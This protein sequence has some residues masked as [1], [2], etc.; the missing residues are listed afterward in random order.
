MNSDFTIGKY[1]YEQLE[2]GL[3]LI[4]QPIEAAPV[5]SVQFAVSTGSIHENPAGHGLSHFLEHMIFKGSE[6]FPGKND[7]A[8]E[9]QRCGGYI[10]AYTT[11][12]HTCYHIDSMSE[13]WRQMTELLVDAMR[14]PLFPEEEFVIEKEVILREQ[15]M[16]EDNPNW[17]LQQA[18]WQIASGTHPF[19]IPVIGYRDKIVEVEREMM[20]NYYKRRYQ[21]RNSAV[22]VVGNVK[23]HEVI[24][25]LKELL[26]DWKNDI[27]EPLVIPQYSRKECHDRR[28]VF[29]EDNQAR[30]MITY[31]LPTGLEPDVPVLD[32]IETILSGSQ[33]AMLINR[34]KKKE[35]LAISV[36]AMSYT[37]PQSG[38]FSC[39]AS[40]VPEK[41]PQVEKKI[42]EIIED[43]REGRVDSKEIERAVLKSRISFLK[44]MQAVS[45]RAQL[46]VTAV[47][48]FDSPNYWEPYLKRL[49]EVDAE[50][51][52]DVA[53][54]YL[55]PDCAVVVNQW[56]EE[57]RE[58]VE[59]RFDEAEAGKTEMASQIE[60]LPESNIRLV[61][62]DR[63]ASPLI[64]FSIVFPD[65]SFIDPKGKAGASFLLS[66]I[67]CGGA[68][69]MNEETLLQVLD[70]NGI[71]LIFSSGN[72]TFRCDV[73]CLPEK[74][75][76]V[77]DLLKQIVLTPAFSETV[78]EREKSNLLQ[79]LE[80]KNK[81]VLGPAVR[82]F[83]S[84]LYG[85]GHP[86]SYSPDGTVE[87]VEN[88]T[89]SDLK[90]LFKLYF[91]KDDVVVAVA[92]ALNDKEGFVAELDSVLNSFE[93][94]DVVVE[95]AI[96][97]AFEGGHQALQIDLKREQ[98]LALVGVPGCDALSDRRYVVD[99]LLAALNGQSSRLFKNIREERGLAYDTGMTARL[100]HHPGHLLLYALTE[101]SRVDATLS[102]LEEELEK[103]V[104]EALTEEEFATAK[105]QMLSE[106]AFDSQESRSIVVNSAINE[107]Y[108]LGYRAYFDELDALK[109][110]S[111]E[112]FCAEVKEMF[113]HQRRISVI[114]G[115]SDKMKAQ[116]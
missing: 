30:V 115:D 35:S 111:Y 4:V 10:N 24:S 60:R 92:G 79:V 19:G 116:G 36:G 78:F 80:S 43:L 93:W 113:G 26:E 77:F 58:Q 18:S 66:R 62:Y 52:K 114:A 21:P 7:I 51:I 1:H 71:S 83:S 5:V 87:T 6:K 82:A 57:C 28:D 29:Y 72:N 14:A 100:G 12:D 31:N 38:I 94:S 9:V 95:K 84:A 32:V 41:L 27:I 104:A 25:L 37:V 69:D 55:D 86:Y 70:D 90:D 54:K 23:A 48:G 63:P 64:Y 40:A 76:L 96:V 22:V 81:K 39:F 33:S 107:Y 50:K 102:L 91:R 44:Q 97:P 99:L 110:I 103:M 42:F 34:L 68:G 46:F 56:P 88:I 106:R 3:K 20:L 74:I 112:T 101:P 75:S 98:A 73:N 67:L 61:T 15:S 13:D 59:K 47:T 108:G 89:L 53:L 109:N 8:D 45:S 65:G 85:E 11:K 17:H 16:Y 105:L 49:A 2:N